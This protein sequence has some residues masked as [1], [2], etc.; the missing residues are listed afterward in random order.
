MKKDLHK[1]NPGSPSGFSTNLKFSVS[2]TREVIKTLCLTGFLTGKNLPPSF[3]VGSHNFIFFCRF[4][5]DLRL[6]NDLRCL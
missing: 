1:S 2:F 6:P 5:S 4:N 3:P